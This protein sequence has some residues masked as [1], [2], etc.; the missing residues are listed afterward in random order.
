MKSKN[1]HRA[2]F[3]H[4]VLFRYFPYWPLFASLTLLALFGAWSYLYITDPV[5]EI[6]AKLLLSERNISATAQHQISK[7]TISKS[8]DERAKLEV[9]TSRSLVEDI[10]RELNLTSQVYD[11]GLLRDRPA[12]ASAPIVVQVRNVDRIKTHKQVPLGYQAREQTVLFDGKQYRLDSW[13][14]SYYGEIRFVK[15]TLSHES[16]SGDFYVSF[17]DF[18]EVTDDLID[19]LK[20][21]REEDNTGVVSIVYRDTDQY[22]GESI[23]EALIKT[24]Q[25][26]VHDVRVLDRAQS[27]VDPVAPQPSIAYASAVALALLLSVGWVTWKEQLG[28]TILFRTEIEDVT[29]IPIAAEISDSQMKD[30]VV[31]DNFR[32]PQLTDQFMQ[33][34]A[35]IQ[36]YGTHGKSVVM[37]TSS[38]A[39][40]GKTFV[41]A[42][43]AISI[44]ASDKKVLLLD[45]DF[46]NPRLSSLY[47]IATT[48][49]AA[50]VLLGAASLQETIRPTAVHNLYLLSAGKR[51]ENAT[52]I[53]MDSDL[54]GLLQ[55]LR[56]T[57]D[58]IVIDTPPVNPVIDGYVISPF[59]DVTL[60]VMRHGNTPKTALEPFRL[61]GKVTTLKNLNI[62]FNG[63][64]PRGMIRSLYPYGY[65]SAYEYG[66]ERTRK[67]SRWFGFLFNFSS[68]SL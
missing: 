21:L 14:R 56:S 6:R 4:R 10:I 18:R 26:E 19:Q 57:F 64:R 53:L 49:G 1:A 32:K 41:S 3:L 33:M 11:E 67:R 5:Y 9:L 47:N 37:V 22:R 27:S 62:V 35:A 36:L 60:F 65:G 39:G 45:L 59:C 42:N 40:E 52:T 23:L 2:S 68:R 44:T 48:A 30:Y 29:S 7:D 8:L 38:N 31:V 43:F 28:S 54:S 25:E 55:K 66:E 50:D 13:I 58:F 12:F 15:N 34:R 46:R 24:Y 51:R 17:Q 16:R 61:N 63:V 20:I